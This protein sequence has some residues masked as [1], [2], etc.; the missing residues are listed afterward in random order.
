[1]SIEVVA[2][3]NEVLSGLVVNTNASYIGKKFAD[4]G[5]MVSRNTVLPDEIPVMV[6]GLKDALQR[7]SVVIVTGGLGPTIDDLTPSAAAQVCRSAPSELSNPVGSAPGFLY[8]ENGKYL[9][10]LPGVPSEMHAMFELHV[11]PTLAKL[12]PARGFRNKIHL[13][14]LSEQEV[15]PLLRNLQQK[16]PNLDIGIYPSY[17][18]LSIALSALSKNPVDVASEEISKK[19]AK[20][21]FTSESGNVEEAIHQWMITHKKTLALAE[22]CTGGTMATLLTALPGAS[23]YFLGSLVTYSDELKKNILGVSSET[24][25]KNGAVSRATVT[26]MLEGIFRVTKADYGIAV[27]GI[28]G[29]GGGS[30]EKPVGT[31]WYA[32]GQR[33]KTPVIDTFLA[34]G[35]RESIIQMTSKRLL[36]FLWLH[37]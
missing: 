37:L 28:A 5:W 10:L 25:E 18:K 27:S 9:F 17:G 22:S 16:Y 15:D 23:Q 4:L 31:V 6:Q 2:I 26:E 3:G 36:S 1:M 33:G 12:F 30:K 20:H 29:P 35:T 13:C 14:F 32:L 24:I 21:L 19:F 7:S 11:L 8:Q 34:K